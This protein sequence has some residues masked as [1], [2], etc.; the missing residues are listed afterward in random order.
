MRIPTI[1][2]RVP[3]SPL[4]LSLSE[5]NLPLRTI[6]ALENAGIFTIEDILHCL[7]KDLLKIDNFGEKALTE[8]FKALKNLGFKREGSHSAAA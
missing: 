6:N 8:V 2:N 7:P 3:K 1:K 4:K 5:A